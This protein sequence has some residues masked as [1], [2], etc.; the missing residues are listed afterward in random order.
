MLCAARRRLESRHD[1][2]RRL[3]C[4]AAVHGVCPT[5]AHHRNNADGRPLGIMQARGAALG[6]VGA[7]SDEI[8]APQPCFTSPRRG[9]SDREAI[10][11]RGD[12]LIQ[13][14]QPLTRPRC[15][16]P[17]PSGEVKMSETMIPSLRNTLPCAHGSVGARVG[18]GLRGRIGGPIAAPLCLERAIARGPR[19]FKACEQARPRHLRWFCRHLES[20]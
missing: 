2:L 15:A 17:L 11:A 14:P 12:C 10:R 8:D 6:L 7:C 4:T 16:R 1:R 3:R 20:A 5:R 19:A 13:S 9:R 18:S